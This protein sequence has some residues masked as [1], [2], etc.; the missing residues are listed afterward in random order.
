M[1]ILLELESSEL[2]SLTRRAGTSCLL[3]SALL[4]RGL[5]V[6]PSLGAIWNSMELMLVSNIIIIYR[7]G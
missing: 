6:I 7:I 3:I 2:L 5:P 1:N 4:L